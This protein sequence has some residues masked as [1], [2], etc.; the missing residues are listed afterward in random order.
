MTDQEQCRALLRAQFPDQGQSLGSVG[1][2]QVARR[3]IGQDQLRPIGQSPGHS[4]PLLLAGRK[5]P[6]KVVQSIAQSDPV[7]QRPGADP[8]RTRPERHPQ[9]DI[10]QT[11]EALE[12][13]E[14]LE[15]VPDDRRPVTI[16]SRFRQRGHVLTIQQNASGVSGQNAGNQVQKRGLTGTA[17][18]T[19]GHLLP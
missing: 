10:L 1:R 5:L 17:R 6:R 15:D 3:F 4:D 14:G 13:I 19:Q 18:A 12:Q 2:V 7:Q 9:K 16:P 11:R 8:I